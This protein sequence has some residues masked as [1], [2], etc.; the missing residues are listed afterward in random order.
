MW[1]QRTSFAAPCTAT[2]VSS[3]AN[4]THIFLWGT[5]VPMFSPYGLGYAPGTGICPRPGTLYPWLL[6]LILGWVHGSP[7]PLLIFY[8][9]DTADRMCTWSCW[10]H[11]K[12]ALFLPA[13]GVS[14]Q[15]GESPREWA[16]HSSGTLSGEKRQRHTSNVIPWGT[17]IQLCLKLNNWDFSV[18]QYILSLLL[19]LLFLLK[20]I[21]KWGSDTKESEL[22]NWPLSKITYLHLPLI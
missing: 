19:L 18:Y 7:Q 6:P 22:I 13:G 9:G 3:L 2:I 8:L 20:S 21:W 4:S 17:W 12:R 16:Q 11:G 1:L 15:Q 10:G 5:D 14:P